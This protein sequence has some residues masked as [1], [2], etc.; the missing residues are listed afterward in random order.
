[1]DGP[2]GLQKYSKRKF[3]RFWF[4]RRRDLRDLVGTF[5]IWSDD[6]RQ[7]KCLLSLRDH[8]LSQEVKKISNKREKTK[9]EADSGKIENFRKINFE[10]L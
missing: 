3:D 8:F 4:K 6:F 9:I 7:V 10:K 1:M 5:E 2:S